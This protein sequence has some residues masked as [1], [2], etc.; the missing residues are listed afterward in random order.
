MR[1]PRAL[2]WYAIFVDEGD[3]ASPV[4]RRGPFAY[5]ELA[6][7]F[8]AEAVDES[9]YVWAEGR[10]DDFQPVRSLPDLHDALLE[11]A[12]GAPAKG[13]P[14]G[15]PKGGRAQDVRSA[16]W[17]YRDAGGVQL[18]PSVLDT[19]KILWDYGELKEDTPVMSDADTEFK[20]LREVPDLL[21]AL[22]LGVAAL[23]P[24]AGAQQR[25]EEK[26]AAAEEERAA[27][28]IQA[29]FRG[30]KARAENPVPKRA[31]APVTAARRE[32]EL[33]ARRREA[34]LAA[35]EADVAARELEADR[36]V[37]EAATFAATARGSP[38]P[39]STP[40]L[41]GG[42]ATAAPPAAVRDLDDDDDDALSRDGAESDE[43][44][45]A[46]RVHR[47]RGG[48]GGKQPRATSAA[49]E[50]L[51]PMPD[52]KLGRARFQ[53]PDAFRSA[54]AAGAGSAATAEET[55]ATTTT[56][57]TTLAGALATVAAPH[58]AANGSG[59]PFT[60]FHGEMAA[61][62][63]EYARVRGKLEGEYG[64]LHATL[65]AKLNDVSGQLQ[66]NRRRIEEAERGMELEQQ[67]LERERARLGKERNRLTER[68]NRES[69]AAEA[70]GLQIDEARRRIGKEVERRERKVSEAERSLKEQRDVLQREQTVLDEE[71]R[72]A[73]RE[74]VPA[75]SVMRGIAL[76]SISRRAWVRAPSRAISREQRRQIWLRLSRP[77][78]AVI[79]AA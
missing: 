77:A 67:E 38:S 50:L 52:I 31:G 40:R 61:L 17:F 71:Q 27:T 19:L 59:G 79:G 74:W 49:D 9:T 58:G 14:G 44:P 42:L 15:T 4:K 13:A 3:A 11:D 18:G 64:A 55:T 47:A 35:R 46:R 66:T 30:K 5:T 78:S 23:G 75:M 21:K 2:L 43:L 57:K 72:R 12:D 53:T 16:R 76:V 51:G 60:M 68:R 22:T 39:R 45:V 1:Q 33:E 25:R 37:M 8:R 36:R 28:Q 24:D 65:T 26:A 56:S 69:A 32:A 73:T 41:Y 70:A 63:A 20:P 48:Y 34:Q 62:E 54:A 6:D 10:M 29:A 7:M